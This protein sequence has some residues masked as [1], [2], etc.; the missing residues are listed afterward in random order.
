MTLPTEPNV[1]NMI[2][3]YSLTE[4]LAAAEYAKWL[5]FFTWIIRM[6]FF[7]FYLSGQRNRKFNRW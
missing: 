5:L 4:E 6:S 7:N 2:D 1:D 3:K